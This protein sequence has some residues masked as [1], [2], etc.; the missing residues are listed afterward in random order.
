MG[1]II[2]KQYYKRICYNKYCVCTYG[3][4]NCSC[5]DVLFSRIFVRITKLNNSDN[6]VTHKFFFFIVAKTNQTNT[7]S[8]FNSNGCTYLLV[9]VWW[10][11]WAPKEILR[12]HCLQ[13]LLEIDKLSP[14]L[15]WSTAPIV[16]VQTRCL[17]RWSNLT[18]D[19]EWDL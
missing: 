13:H 6:M 11:C 15:G 5:E 12:Q 17:A 16:V 14:L 19:P 7:L 8:V 1:T 4:W 10:C 2:S 3:F 9:A 18:A